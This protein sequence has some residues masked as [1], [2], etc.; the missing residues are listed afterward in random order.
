MTSK[1]PDYS[2]RFLLPL[3]S[4]IAAG[5]LAFLLYQRALSFAFFNDDPTGHF[6]WMEERSYVDFFLSSADYGYYRP[7]VFVFLKSL[8]Q[9]AGYWAPAFH[10]LLLFLHTANVGMIWLLTYRLSG[11][12]AYAWGSALIFATVPFSYEAVA[13]VASL[14]HPL[15]LSWLL[16][17]LL[18]YRAARHAAGMKAT[19]YFGAAYLTMIL[20]LF[21]HENGL[22]IPLALIGI[23]W[24]E[25]P[26]QGLGDAWRRPFRAFLIAPVIFFLLWLAIPKTGEQTMATAGA[27]ASNPVP[28]LQTLV[29]PLLP[30]FNLQAGQVGWLVT[31]A[32][33]VIMGTLLLARFGRALGLWAF[34]LAWWLLSSLPAILFLEP[35]YLYGSPRLHY[36]P[37]V[38]VALLWALPLLVLGR[39]QRGRYAAVAIAGV[40][41]AYILLMTVPPL[42]FVRCQLDFYAEASSIVR[43]MADVAGIAPTEEPLVFVNLPFFFSSYGER[44]EGCPNPYPWTPVGAVVVPPYA[45]AGDFVRFN[46]GP[47][48]EVTAVAVLAYGPGWSTVGEETPVEELLAVAATTPTFAFELNNSDFRELSGIWR[49]PA[50]ASAAPLAVF[51]D[52][53]QLLDANVTEVE[54]DAVQVTLRWRA[55]SPPQGPITAFVHLYDAAG[56]LVAQHDA[57]PAQGYVP[58]HLWQPEAVIVDRHLVQLPVPRQNAPALTVAAGLYDPA[59]GTRLAAEGRLVRDDAAVLGQLPARSS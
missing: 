33:A 40:Q 22:F 26:P 50:N 43:E 5:A 19:I 46:G 17:T 25:Q 57:P 31:L 18:F 32:G 49:A 3:L 56:N 42:P 15:L 16:L 12:I 38:G 2:S 21:T 1:R 27:L 35:S 29:Y 4:V 8:V 10:A 37:A 7:V 9:S 41:V 52:N 55:T 20:G 53:V 6:A 30:A 11:S 59:T 58:W 48:R 28:F 47:A 51:D 34:G 44:P 14:T 23:E 45:S 36:L 13:Y 39:L 54:A 24:L